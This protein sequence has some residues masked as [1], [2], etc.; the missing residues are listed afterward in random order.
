MC[1]SRPFHPACVLLGAAFSVWT[2]GHTSFFLSTAMRLAAL[3]L[4]LLAALL[5]VA[6]AQPYFTWSIFPS[7]GSAPAPRGQIS[8]ALVTFPDGNQKYIVYGGAQSPAATGLQYNDMVHIYDIHSSVVRQS[9]FIETCYFY[10]QTQQWAFDLNTLQWNTVPAT[11][12][13]LQPARLGIPFFLYLPLFIKKRVIYNDVLIA[14]TACVGGAMTSI[15][16]VALVMFG[17]FS[18]P[19]NLVSLHTLTCICPGGADANTFYDDLYIFDINKYTF[20]LQQ[21]PANSQ[22]P[23]PRRDFVFFK[24]TDL[25]SNQKLLYVFGGSSDKTLLNGVIYCLVFYGVLCSLTLF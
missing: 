22:R 2:V 4:L 17:S 11:G 24:R 1:F 16:Q 7:T 8:G 3:L 25:V 18:S 6:H 12:N 15:D 14:I 5:I 13:I 19:S 20:A 21:F 10:S 9:F 23:Q